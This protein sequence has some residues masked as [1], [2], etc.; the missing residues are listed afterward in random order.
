MTSVSVALPYS[1]PPLCP[2]PSSQVRP[3]AVCAS[4]Y[5]GNVEHS[6]LV[7]VRPAVAPLAVAPPA[8]R[9]LTRRMLATGT[10]LFSAANVAVQLSLAWCSCSSVGQKLHLAT[11]ATY[12]ALASLSIGRAIGWI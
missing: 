12:A 1:V 3:V 5:A 10:C 2:V 9:F 8:P 7:G 4:E 11:A 6:F